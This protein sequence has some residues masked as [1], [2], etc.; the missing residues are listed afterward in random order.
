MLSKALFASMTGPRGG[1][2]GIV[3]DDAESIADEQVSLW[4]LYAL[5]E[6][7]VEGVDD[8]RE[9]DPGLLAVRAGLE[10]R[11]EARLWKRWDLSSEDDD[12][13]GDASIAE[14]LFALAA[15]AEGPSVADHVR[16]DATADQVLQLLRWRSL[17]HL[18]E[19]DPSTWVIPRLGYRAKAALV[20]LQ[21]DEYGAGR[22][23][24][25]HSHLF[26]LGM[27]AAG[28]D[29][30]PGA[31]VDEAPIE[32]LELNNAM[33]LFGLHRAYRAA[34]M[35]HLA[36]FEATSSLPS[37]RM[38]QGLSRLG[39][40]DELVR[41]YDEHVEADAVHEQVAARGIA[42]A[43]AAD[44]PELDEQ[45]MF[46]AFTCIDLERRF[47]TRALAEWGSRGHAG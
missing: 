13:T 25:L 31:Y 1:R 45:V 36:A 35:G 9:W 34:A 33:S 19:A 11:F 47:A 39:L 6:C 30:A 38:S 4:T 43:L 40:P 14:R 29:T 42:A 20:E 21:Y 44:E 16:R 5:H 7:G 22:P 18:R 41:Y 24:L 28:L 3:A 17:Y 27:R 2:E 12:A 23:E 32:V 37:R 15:A 46:G 10:K 26:A 8:E